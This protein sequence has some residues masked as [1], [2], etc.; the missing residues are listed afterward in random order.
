MRKTTWIWPVSKLR[1][2]LAAISFPEYQREPTVWSRAAKRLLI[3]SMLRQFDI[4][5]RTVFFQLFQ[6]ARSDDRGRYHWV[7]KEPGEGNIG[8]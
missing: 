6:G 1:S 4:R 2:K 5:H 3:D 8:Q 7:M